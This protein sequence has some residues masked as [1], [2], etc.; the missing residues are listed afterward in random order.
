M[1]LKDNPYAM[2]AIAFCSDD[3]GKDEWIRCLEQVEREDISFVVL[4]HV[5]S[6]LLLWYLQ[7]TPKAPQY[8]LALN[9]RFKSAYFEVE[10]TEE[11][12]EGKRVVELLLRYY[13]EQ[14]TELGS[15]TVT[16]EEWDPSQEAE[17]AEYTDQLEA[18]AGYLNTFFNLS[19]PQEA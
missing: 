16:Y 4:D 15:D 1:K 5:A 9:P 14:G 8:K 10:D 13:S 17:I 11:N 3:P 19:K 7:Q 6:G 18:F 2:S 12:E